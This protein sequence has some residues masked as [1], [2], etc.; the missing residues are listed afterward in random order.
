MPAAHRHNHLYRAR[1]NRSDRRQSGVGGPFEAHSDNEPAGSSNLRSHDLLAGVDHASPF[2]A[3]HG[4][5]HEC[6]SLSMAWVGA[7]DQPIWAGPPVALK[8][9][10]DQIRKRAGHRT[11][12][13]APEGASCVYRPGRPD[14]GCNRRNDGCLA[15]STAS[16]IFI[17]AADFAGVW[18]REFG[19]RSMSS[20]WT[21]AG[22]RCR[23]SS[24]L[25]S[26]THGLPGLSLTR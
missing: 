25:S 17:F 11:R 21:A 9:C 18:L 1:D 4:P 22:D 2:S 6:G 10:P 20:S 14:L 8:S 16:L 5:G 19:C 15:S 26:P 13:K 12:T 24:P 23:S 7:P 3:Q